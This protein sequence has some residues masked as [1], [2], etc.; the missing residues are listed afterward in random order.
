MKFEPS[1]EKII[2][3]SFWYTILGILFS[4]KI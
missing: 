2:E 1:Q 4:P 3:P